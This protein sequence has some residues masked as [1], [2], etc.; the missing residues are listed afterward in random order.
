MEIEEKIQEFNEHIKFLKEEEAILREMEIGRED[1]ISRL[2][3]LA[4]EAR[5]L[6]EEFFDYYAQ[7]KINI[8]N[9]FLFEYNLVK[10]EI[11]Y[12]VSRITSNYNS[13]YIMEKI[14]K[15]QEEMEL[16]TRR[17]EDHDR[18]MLNIMGILL[19]IF[20][21][22]GINTGIF[23]VIKEGTSIKEIITLVIVINLSLS[24][25]MGV[26]FLYIKL[27]FNRKEK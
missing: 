13:Y 5:E 10:Q 6:E 2:R 12:I 9:D 25:S 22:V 3:E 8:V 27:I 14:N 24:F 4:I 18:N 20:S 23:G 7:N 21:L 15:Q 26:L 16:Q 1:R 17:I 11:V 19:A